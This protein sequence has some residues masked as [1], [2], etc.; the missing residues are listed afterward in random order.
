MAIPFLFLETGSLSVTQAGEQWCNLGSLQPPP[1]RFK[2]FSCLSLL[3]SWDHAW[4]IFVFFGRDRV[5]PWWP[6]WS[7]TPDLKWFTHLGLTKSWDY[8][9]GLLCL[10][11]YFYFFFFFNWSLAL[12]PRLECNGAILAHRNLRL[13]GSGNS[14]ASASWAA[15]ITGAHHHAQVI[16]K[17]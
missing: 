1:L 7:W 10:A 11:F 13:L 17:F 6:G 14:P 8:S 16:F 15:G 9:H 5:L 2:R 3:S 12:L 4:Q